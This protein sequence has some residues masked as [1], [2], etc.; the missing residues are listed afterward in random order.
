MKSYISYYM[1]IKARNQVFIMTWTKC[2]LHAGKSWIIMWSICMHDS[3][4]FTSFLRFKVCSVVGYDNNSRYRHVQVDAYE[5][6]GSSKALLHSLFHVLGRYHEH[7]RGDREE[8][9]QVIKEHVMEGV[10]IHTYMYMYN[11]YS[12]TL[13]SMQTVFLMSNYS[14]ESKT[15]T[16]GNLGY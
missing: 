4:P 6:H 2:F 11:T 16:L 1:Y 13:F 7:Q 12:C 15:V 10:N 14:I 9:I 8:Y 5:K 3:T